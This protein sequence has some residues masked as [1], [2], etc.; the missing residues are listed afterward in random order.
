MLALQNRNCRFGKPE[1]IKWY[2]IL[3]NCLEILCLTPLL[4]PS[5]IWHKSHYQ[6]VPGKWKHFCHWQAGASLNNSMLEGYVSR[7]LNFLCWI[8]HWELDILTSYLKSLSVGKE[9]HRIKEFCYP[10]KNTFLG[11]KLHLTHRNHFNLS[12]RIVS[13]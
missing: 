9:R 4:C 3:S 10:G 12:S 13:S 8:F 5:L 2:F 6:I 1:K 11:L 7:E